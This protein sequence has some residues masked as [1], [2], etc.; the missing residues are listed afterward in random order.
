MSWDPA[1][2]PDGPA[3]RILEAIAQAS[4]EPRRNYEFGVEEREGGLLIGNCRLSPTGRNAEASMGY[5]YRRDRWGRGYGTEVVIALL[6]FGFGQLGLHRISASAHVDN[7]ASWRVMEKAG[8]RRDGRLR[9]GLQMSSG[10]ADVLLYAILE[11]DP[12]PGFR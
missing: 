7:V 3:R 12:R 6:D 2:S 9:D 11:G 8:M 10:W 5:V 4:E 1:E